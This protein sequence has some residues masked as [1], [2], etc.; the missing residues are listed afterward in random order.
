M[1]KINEHCSIFPITP[2]EIPEV[3][4]YFLDSDP[5]DHKKR[6]TDTSKLPSFAEWHSYML[7]EYEKPLKEKSYFCLG[8]WYDD[9][10]IGHSCIDHIEFGNESFTHL[11]I[12]KPEFRYK[13]LGQ[14][15]FWLSLQYYFKHFELKRIYCQPNANNSAPNQVLRDLGFK[16]VKNYKTIPHPICFE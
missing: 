2:K 16:L 11:H 6:G 14:S 7:S 9:Q 10:L 15:L 1:M 4:C 5:A 13:K 3:I 12:W 8:W